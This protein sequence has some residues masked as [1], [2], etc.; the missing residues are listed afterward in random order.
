VLEQDLGFVVVEG[1]IG[2]GKTSLARKLADTLSAEL[3]LEPAEENPF[4][5]RF[6]RE[7]KSAALSAQLFF[8]LRRS[9]QLKDLHQQGLFSPTR[10]ADF[11]LAKDR[12]FADLVLD[13]PERD[14]YGQ[15]YD[16]VSVDSVTPDLVIYLQAPP[17]TL[18]QRIV[19]RGIDY[20]Q[21]IGIDYLE[22]LS[23]AYTRFFHGFDAA[24]TLIVNTEA[25]DP[26]HREKDYEDLVRQIREMRGGRHYFNPG[27]RG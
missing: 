16:H 25:F 5:E 27:P 20:E 14:L 4:L 15:I 26:V 8:L 11:M 7:P 23:A 10:V 6:Y 19:D 2:V 9:Q 24:P 22:R 1:P 13:P 12:L 18:R 17:E 21:R 3:I